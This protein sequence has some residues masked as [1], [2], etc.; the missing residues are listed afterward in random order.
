MGSTGS[1]GGGPRRRLAGSRAPGEAQAPDRD[2]DVVFETAIHCTRTLWRWGCW[3][4]LALYAAAASLAFAGSPG[5]SLPRAGLQLLPGVLGL[6]L[7]FGHSFSE[8]LPLLRRV[9]AAGPLVRH[10]T[11]A[12]DKATVDA[13]GLLEGVGILLATWLFVGPFPLPGLPVGIRTAGLVVCIAYNWS[14]VLQAVIDAGWYSVTDPP[15]H[16]MLVF[17]RVIPPAHCLVLGAVMWPWSTAAGEVPAGVVAVLCLSPLLYYAV[18]AMFGAMLRAAVHTAL[19]QRHLARFNSA[20]AV[21][22]MLK[23]SVGVLARYAE[24]DDPPPDLG[25]LRSLSREVLIGVEEAR[26]AILRSDGSGQSGSVREVWLQLNPLIEHT[27]RGRH[28]ECELA[29]DVDLQLTSTDYQRARSLL[30]D[31]MMNA[32]KAHA[33]RVRIEFRVRDPVRPELCLLRVSDDGQRF[34][35]GAARDPRTSLKVQDVLLARYG[36]GIDV[37]DDGQWKHITA[38]WGCPPGIVRPLPGPQSPDAPVTL[39]GKV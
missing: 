22:S 37:H 9:P 10:L 13:S 2:A 6:V 26:Q 8:T 23:N 38:R 18:W 39:P 36:G 17:R 14:A 34:P 32:L 7:A 27:W 35:P 29:G 19:A 33:R 4:R 24:Q 1:G 25:H 28:E 5:A 15:P 16:G 12:R 21:H 20:S 30:S 3:V 31:L 11:N